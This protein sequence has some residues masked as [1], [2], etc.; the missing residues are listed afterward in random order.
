MGLE[1]C[2]NSDVGQKHSSYNPCQG[3]P[4][5]QYRTV[6]RV[7]AVADLFGTEES[8]LVDEMMISAVRAVGLILT[9]DL[10]TG[11]ADVGRIDL[12]LVGSIDL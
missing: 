6:G 10:D 9:E 3:G 11:L 5:P 7:L 2:R 1:R 8:T 4:L 12:L